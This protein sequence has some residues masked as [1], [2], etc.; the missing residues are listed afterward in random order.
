M[1]VKIKYIVECNICDK[2]ESFNSEYA[3]FNLGWKRVYLFLDQKRLSDYSEWI[4]CSTCC[5]N[6]NNIWHKGLF[7][8]IWDK[9]TNSTPPK[10][11]E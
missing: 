10:E 6:V 2:E 4:I 8:V 11:R 1:P 5:G 7:K 3:A 9:L